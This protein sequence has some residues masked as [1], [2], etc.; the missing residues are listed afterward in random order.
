M[1][2]AKRCLESL[3][4]VSA[5]VRRKRDVTESRQQGIKSVTL[6][7]AAV[8]T[9]WQ[10][11]EAAARVTTLGR[12]G[13]HTSPPVLRGER[14]VT[15]KQKH[16]RAGSSPSLLLSWSPLLSLLLS[17]SCA[18]PT[19]SLLHPPAPPWP[20]SHVQTTQHHT[21]HRHYFACRGDP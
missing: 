1:V 16:Q 19:S 2:R 20:L 5:C 4:S 12:R 6:L 13:S 7:A 17:D 18:P 10:H 3:C 14:G 21:S 9:R 15:G 11:G 8:L